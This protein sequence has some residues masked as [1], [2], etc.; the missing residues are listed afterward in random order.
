MATALVDGKLLQIRY[1]RPDAAG[2]G[3]GLTNTSVDAWTL[4]EAVTNHAAGM[5]LRFIN[6]GTFL[7]SAN[8]FF[9]TNG[10]NG[11]PIIF[12]GRNLTDTAYETAY[13]YD[14]AG[15]KFLFTGYNFEIRYLDFCGSS[16]DYVVSITGYHTVIHN[17]KILNTS[18]TSTDFGRALD[19]VYGVAFNNYLESR[20]P[21]SSSTSAGTLKSTQSNIFGNKIVT[22]YRGVSSAE[23][24]NFYNNLVIG[25]G[26]GSGY[27]ISD[28]AYLSVIENNTFYNFNYGID[29]F[30][31]SDTD[32]NTFIMN[33]LFHTITGINDP[34]DPS[35]CVSLR[36]TKLQSDYH[37]NCISN[38]YYNCDNFMEEDKYN[39][40]NVE[41]T[42]DP[43][44]YTDVNPS[45]DINPPDYSLNN[46]TGGGAACKNISYPSLTWTWN[47]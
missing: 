19:I 15:G 2:G 33:N 44:V 41:C 12:S 30:A 7:S 17:C 39:L 32:A 45:Y 28:Y 20:T 46:V 21:I 47:H 14:T 34:S 24:V 3:T 37:L 4:T 38:R 27:Y 23:S 5:E 11:N 31:T 35:C 18:T 9:A 22:K 16:T 26:S 13:I 42:S 29:L 40:N 43:F 10:T 36:Q 1:V 8:K 6:A 25:N